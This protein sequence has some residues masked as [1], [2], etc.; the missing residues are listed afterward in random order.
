MSET[1]LRKRQAEF[2]KELHGNEIGR[3]TGLSALMSKNNTAQKEAVQKYLKHWDGKTDKD[4]EE[5]RLEDYNEATHSY[6]NVVTD[7]YEYGWGSSF[8]FSRFYKGES[9]AA[10]IARHEHYLAY[11]AGI[12]KDDLV[13]DVGCGVGGP[14]REIARFTGCNVIGLNN[15]DYQI[16]K[17]KYYAEKY[18]LS[19]Q[20]DFVKGDFMHMDFEENT[21]DRVYAIEATCHAPKLE[22]VY[23]E[24][25][26][27]L[28]PGGTFAVYEWVMTDN[29]DENNAEH[30]KIAYEIELGDGIPKMFHVDVAKQALK[31]CGFEVLVSEDLADNEDEIPWYYPLTGEWKYVQNLANLATFFRT[32]YLG[33]QF[34]TT[35]VSLMERFGLAPEG[36]KEVTAAL[37]NAAVGL[38]AGGRSKLFT[39]MMLFVAKKPAEVEASTKTS[40]KATQ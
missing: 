35:M 21:F 5:R 22:G 34:T 11:K 12:K 15:N 1:E 38:V 19:D 31:N 18:N 7:F 36:S 23:S 39:P 27:V 28:K 32:S 10:S 30:R 29:Y 14:A 26:K 2:T 37:E 16:A 20:M 9:F 25:Y 8:H 3:K 33:R 4:A 6:Y 17:A 24:I 13:L 40:K